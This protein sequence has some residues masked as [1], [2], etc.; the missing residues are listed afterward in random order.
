MH[1]NR[2]VWGSYDSD[3]IRGAWLSADIYGPITSQLRYSRVWAGFLLWVGQFFSFLSF[4]MIWLAVGLTVLIAD[5]LVACA[6]GS[7]T[8]TD[9]ISLSLVFYCCCCC[10]C[11]VFFTTFNCKL[12]LSCMIFTV[13]HD[14]CS[15]RLN[16]FFSNR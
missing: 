11:C 8:F 15:K 9:F 2:I 1:C 10:N 16:S 3:F 5:W 14:F 4:W 13:K 12:I 7:A 6:D